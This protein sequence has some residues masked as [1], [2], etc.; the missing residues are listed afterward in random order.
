MQ[1]NVGIDVHSGIVDESPHIEQKAI[2]FD[3][4]SYAI[5]YRYIHHNIVEAAHEKRNK[6]T[7]TTFLSFN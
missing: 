1:K 6:D 5:R 4:F 3:L 2:A 7:G